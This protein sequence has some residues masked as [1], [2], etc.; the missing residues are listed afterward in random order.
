M[1]KRV[2]TF[3]DNLALA[4]KI[5]EKLEQG[6]L[7]LEETLKEYKAGFDYLQECQQMLQQAELEFAELLASNE[8][9]EEKVE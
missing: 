1:T 9:V 3:E 4:T 2:K 6:E 5:V 7:G 8:V